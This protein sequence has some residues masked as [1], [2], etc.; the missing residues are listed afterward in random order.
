MSPSNDPHDKLRRALRE[1]D[2]QLSEADARILVEDPGP[3][4]E[5]LFS[6]FRGKMWVSSLLVYIYIILF[7]GLAVFCGVQFFVAETT[8]DWVMY[9]VG[10]TTAVGIVN[11]VKLWYWMLANRNAVTRE[12][13]RLELQV[14]RLAEI[15]E[16]KE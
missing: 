16:A 5:L 15:I 7:S 10:F 2:P 12:V 6:Q 4:R 8:R 9:G 1:T 14:S 11:V 3:I 13:K